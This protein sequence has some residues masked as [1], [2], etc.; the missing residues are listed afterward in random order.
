MPK[1]KIP[2]TYYWLNRDLAKV[3]LNTQPLRREDD[4]RAQA[5]DL[6]ELEI[7]ISGEKVDIMENHYEN[8]FDKILDYE[9]LNDLVQKY[10]SIDEEHWEKFNF[11][12]FMSSIDGIEDWDN[13]CKTPTKME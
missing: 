9:N 2:E 13:I 10:L 8:Q 3:G 6:E 11:E 5:E 7:Q 12:D 1:S 4:P